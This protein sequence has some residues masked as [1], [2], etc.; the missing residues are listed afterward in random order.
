MQLVFTPETYYVE[1]TQLFD[2]ESP[3][4]DDDIISIQYPVVNTNFSTVNVEYMFVVNRLEASLVYGLT[5]VAANSIGETRSLEYVTSQTRDEGIMC[6]NC[7]SMVESA[8][9]I[10][11]CVC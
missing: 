2:G 5:V 1:Y 3:T 4:T 10:Y 8:I 11:M 6:K 9:F 7:Y